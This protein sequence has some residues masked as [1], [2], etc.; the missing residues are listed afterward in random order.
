MNEYP[1]VLAIAGSEPMGSAGVQADIKAI[2][3]CGSY[4]AGALTWW[5]GITYFVNKVRRQ[6]NLRG[7]W[8]LTRVIGGIVIVASL[9]GFFGTLLGKSLY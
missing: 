3:A 8:I 2:S 4:A 5:F 6:F 9:A 7:I 1:K